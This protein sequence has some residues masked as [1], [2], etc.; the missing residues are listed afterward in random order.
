MG[1]DGFYVFVDVFEGYF[2]DVIVYVD[3]YV[4]FLYIGRVG[5]VMGGWC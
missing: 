4:G 3:G 5:W 2:G 1:V